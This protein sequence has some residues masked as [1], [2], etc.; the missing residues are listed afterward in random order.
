MDECSH[1]GK[2]LRVQTWKKKGYCGRKPSK[3]FFCNRSHYEKWWIKNI[4][5][6]FRGEGNARWSQRYHKICLSC[7]KKFV[8][9]EHRKGAKFCSH[10][11][12]ARW[13]FLGSKNPRWRGGMEREVRDKL[14]EYK[15]WRGA[16]WKR[17]KWTCKI[18]SYR[19]KRIVA[20]HIQVWKFFVQE[21]FKVENGITLCR[22]CHCRLHTIYKNTI[23]FSEILRDYMPSL[24]SKKI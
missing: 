21:R 14:P 18:C 1:C 19:G 15:N 22:V 20:H 10:S 5:S 12:S 13:Y 23:D 17:D 7:R 8:V 4:A 11:C 3:H 6:K 2:G 16:V 24:L 9:V